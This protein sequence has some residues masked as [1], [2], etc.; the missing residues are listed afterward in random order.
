[1]AKSNC[2]KIKLLKIMEILRQETDEDHPMK[3]YAICERLVSM[4][5]SCDR[6]TLHL[7]MKVLN[8]QGFDIID[9]AYYI[10][11]TL[12]GTE[13]DYK[14]QTY[15]TWSKE[16]QNIFITIARAKTTPDKTYSSSLVSKA[17]NKWN[18]LNVNLRRR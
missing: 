13:L 9:I 14:Y 4:G 5:I 12:I 3:T 17:L 16:R 2:Q 11:G 1:M 18:T 10:E 6:R 8:E 15:L 7:D